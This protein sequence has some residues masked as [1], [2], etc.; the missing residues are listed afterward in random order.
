MPES[1]TVNLVE[2]TN[3]LINVELIARRS[4]G[5]DIVC[6]GTT[7]LS[8]EIPQEITPEKC[9]K[10]GRV[11][12][13]YTVAYSTVVLGPVGSHAFLGSAKMGTVTGPALESTQNR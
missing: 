2:F 13:Q 12:I 1:G 7:D 9:L 5:R 6:R 11:P 10:G 4:R 3:A 8:S